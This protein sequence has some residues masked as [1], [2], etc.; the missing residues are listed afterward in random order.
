MKIVFPTPVV[1]DGNDSRYLQRDGAR[2]AE[3]FTNIGHTGIKLILDDGKGLPQPSS[4]LL[5]KATYSDWCS[6]KFWQETN[7]DIV[8]LYG[9]LAKN[10]LPVAKAIKQSNAKLILK[11]DS[12]FGI[13]GFFDNTIINI[14]RSYWFSKQG[15]SCFQSILI[16]LVK[17]FS[18]LIKRRNEF[19]TEYLSYFDL[20]TA[21]N[22]YAVE[23]TKKWLINNKLEDINK[24][25]EFMSH[26]VPEHFIYIQDS[27]PKENIVIA[28][29]MNWANPLKRGKLLGKS[30]SLFLKLKPN[31]K[32]IIVG[33][34][35]NIITDQISSNLLSQ[36]EIHPP[37][38]SN[39]IQPLYSKS[40][41]FI[42]PSGSEGSPN[43]LTE[44]LC[45]GCSE[46]ISPE[47]FHLKY[48]E[49]NEDGR[50]AKKSTPS[51]FTKAIIAEAEKWNTNLYNPTEICIKYSKLFHT[52]Q[53]AKQILNT[54]N[55]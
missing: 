46:V 39:D 35:T 34:N 24:R 15:K 37:M 48:I 47:L 33:N 52:P 49:E 41:I 2:L 20:I 43:V 16:A 28:V 22:P 31:W 36:V 5:K 3:Y 17:Q 32:A 8:L 26:P 40:K 51:E 53:I 45:C 29:A 54:K 1:Y 19:L 10:M 27:L 25:V 6:P 9:G 44:S 21:E 55:K 4:H 30:L 42:L 50:L 13:I 18:M 14:K 11:M 23:T 38:L 7:A 12:A